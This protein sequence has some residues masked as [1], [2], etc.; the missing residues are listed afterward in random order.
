[1][2]AKEGAAMLHY[3]SSLNFE[4]GFAQEWLSAW[5]SRDIEAILSHVQEGCTYLSPV[6]LEITGSELVRGKVALRSYLTCAMRRAEGVRFGF[7]SSSWGRLTRNL[8]IFYVAEAEHFAIFCC[9]RM[10]FDPEGLQVAGY[11]Y[12]GTISPIKRVYVDTAAS[13]V[14]AEVREGEVARSVPG[15]AVGKG[16]LGSAERCV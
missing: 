1:M 14:P 2:P 7:E 9:E 13:D 4:F 11:G 5:N 3:N 16:C 10:V 8:A 15:L 12:H 6:A